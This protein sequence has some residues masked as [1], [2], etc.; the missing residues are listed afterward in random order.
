M[1]TP[2]KGVFKDKKYFSSVRN[3]TLALLDAFS[4]VN[5]WVDHDQEEQKQ[6]TVPIS[7][8]NYEKAQVLGD[9]DETQIRK[10]NYNFLPRIV[11]SFDGM[12]KNTQRQTQKYQRLQKLTI[13]DK[14]RKLDI[15]YNSISYDY[16]FRLLVQA[17]GL[18]ISSMIT[19]EILSK[20]NPSLNLLIH[21]FPIFIDKTETQILISDPSFEIN[22]DQEDES[23]NIIQVS[24]DIVVR[25]NVYSQIEMQGPI[26]TVKMFSHLWDEA[27]MKKSKMASYFKFDVNQDQN[28]G[29]IGA[30]N[31]ETGRWFNG[32]I[33]F[34]P[35]IEANEDK[36]IQ[37]RP[38]Y[39]PPEINTTY[40]IK[41]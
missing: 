17:R 8:G 22:E 9:L 21:E 1:Q 16:N 38:D 31:N 20:F 28:N 5:Y 26:E 36:V 6:F 33:P 37:E 27:E 30:V 32:T 12:A 19:E 4:G 11:L 35:V 39:Q 18:T 13:S 15:S 34:D 3:Y 2:V 29:K 14:N 41:E 25:G 24:F 7:F 10:G 23:V 40:D